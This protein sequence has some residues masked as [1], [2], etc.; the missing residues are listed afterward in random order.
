MAAAVFR[1]PIFHPLPKP[2]PVRRAMATASFYAAPATVD[3]ASTSPRWRKLPVLLFD[4]MD[5]LVRDPF[6]NDVPAFFQFIL[7]IMSRFLMVSVFPSSL[8]GVYE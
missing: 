8:I 3:C 1:P 4:V 2:A 5:T 7:E 6:Y